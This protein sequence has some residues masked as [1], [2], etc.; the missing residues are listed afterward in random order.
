MVQSKS[1]SAQVVTRRGF[2][3]RRDR[4]EWRKRTDQKGRFFVVSC[5]FCVKFR[6]FFQLRS[7]GS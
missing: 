1:L 5:R 2:E 3:S 4:Q 6:R 7:T